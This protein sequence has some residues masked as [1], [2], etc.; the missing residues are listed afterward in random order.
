[1]S[2]LRATFSALQKLC[3]VTALPA[4]KRRGFRTAVPAFQKQVFRER[5]Q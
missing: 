5:S 2:A 1:M 4:L 3:L